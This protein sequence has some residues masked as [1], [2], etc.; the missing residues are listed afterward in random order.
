[1][2]GRPRLEPTSWRVRGAIAEAMVAGRRV[3]IDAD[4]IELVSG[5]RWSLVRG[6]YVATGTGEPR[7]VL[8]HRL[9]LGLTPGD[10]RR[11]D[12]RNHD[13]LDN[14][15]DNLRVAST[16]QNVHNSR[17]KF[18][19]S[20]SYKGVRRRRDRFYAYI[21]DGACQVFL[22]GFDTEEAAAR[23]YDRA[24]RRLFGQFACLNFPH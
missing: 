5:R 8:L 22:G 14:R 16:A 23:A 7:T 18:H 1:M 9:L 4:D 6:S 2:I 17:R 15:R 10:P 24:A 21:R 3:V 19:G 11:S 13:P 20:Q 12:H